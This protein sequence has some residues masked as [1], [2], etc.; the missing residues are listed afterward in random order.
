MDKRWYPAAI[1]AVLVG[2]GGVSDPGGGGNSGG[3][4]GVDAGS[5]IQT[6][7][8]VAYAYGVLRVTGGA[9]GTGGSIA[10]N[11]TSETGG[12][13][14]TIDAGV[15]MQSGG[16]SII[17]CWYGCASYGV[18]RAPGGASATLSTSGAVGTDSASG[19][20]S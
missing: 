10:T 6:G 3:T 9:Q 14:N 7:G 19:S 11:S 13:S 18:L 12:T 5:P 17:T 2:C 16:M 4:L 20:S 15:P 1:T 8:M